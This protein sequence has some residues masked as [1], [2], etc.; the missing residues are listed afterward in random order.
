MDRDSRFGY[1]PDIV[2]ERRREYFGTL[3][4]VLRDI[5]PAESEVAEGFGDGSQLNPEQVARL[6]NTKAHGLGTKQYEHYRDGK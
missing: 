1:H 4:R 5:D 6:V 3:F 2:T